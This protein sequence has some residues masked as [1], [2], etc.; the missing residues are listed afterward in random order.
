MSDDF[1]NYMDEIIAAKDAEMGRLLEANA[2]W[3]DEAW[4]MT[5]AK[6]V[7]ESENTRLK[8]DADF[9]NRQLVTKDNRIQQLRETLENLR[10]YGID[11]DAEIAVK[12]SLNNDLIANC[13]QLRNRCWKAESELAR[14]R[15]IAIDLKAKEIQEAN[16]G[17]FVNARGDHIFRVMDLGKCREQAAKELDLQV[18]QEA[19]YVERLEK[20]YSNLWRMCYGD[21]KQD[22]ATRIQAAL[23]KIREGKP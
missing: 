10:Q 14:W 23:T 5:R 3:E 11:R 12:D 15:Q 21:P 20:D 9:M 6:H 19:G 18:T 16:S 13:N 17:D 4:K 2:F 1:A 8:K 7:F 22:D